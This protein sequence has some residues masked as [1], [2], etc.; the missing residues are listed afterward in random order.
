M[1]LGNGYVLTAGHVAD[2]AS[3]F[4]VIT[5]DGLSTGAQLMW[6]NKEYDVALLKVE[7]GDFASSPLSCATPP[8]GTIIEAKGNPLDF[9][10]LSFRGH[11]AGKPV[12]FQRWREIVVMDISGA[13]G[14]SGGPVYNMHG[15]VVGIFVGAAIVPIG[16]MY[17]SLGGLSIAVPGSTIC[18]VMGRAI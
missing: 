9:E 15:E 11:I 4:R 8:P 14:I 7:D 17:P 10:W 12:E 5:D 13:P 3:K 16:G 6:L 2:G 18:K 1:H